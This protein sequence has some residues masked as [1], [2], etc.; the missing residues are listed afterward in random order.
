MKQRCYNRHKS[1]YEN[2]GGRGIKVCKRWL[3]G[4]ENFLKDMG[5]KPEGMSLERKNND[6]D[7]SKSNCYWAT[8]K[9]QANNRRKRRS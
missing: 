4:F 7:Y 9:Q 6:K 3:E 5:E 1:G 8:P 2:Y